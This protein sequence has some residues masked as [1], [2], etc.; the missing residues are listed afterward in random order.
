M[1]IEIFT[2]TLSNVAKILLF[3]ALGYALR[4]SKSFPRESGKTLSILAALIFSPAYTIRSLARDFTVDTLNQKLLLFGYGMVF[5]VAAVALG[6]LT[7][8]L[9]GRDDM[10]KRVFT[11]A[12]AFSNFGYFGYP[13]VESVFGPEILAD[14]IVFSQIPNVAVAT[15]GYW[16]L[17]KQSN[18]NWK[19][20][21]LSPVVWSPFVGAALGLSGWV[22]PE[23]V[24]G[25]LLALGNCM[26]PTVMILMGFVL[27]GVPVGKLFTNLRAYGISLVR[28][29]ALPLI[30][31]ALF[32]LCG[33]RGIWFF[34]PVL[35]FAMPIGANVVV[36]PESC[37]IDTSNNAK[38]VF[39]SYVLAVGILPVAFGIVTAIAGM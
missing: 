19:S 4:N 9:L 16:L 20:F 18:F 35:T 34:L 7:A 26:S 22:L 17:T 10:E 29:V 11:Y 31:G 8:R 30:S 5:V 37:G 2:L 23:L 33:A 25:T 14:Y 32:Y 21:L 1:N 39:L 28:L 36:F 15:F 13:L 24:D 12:F 27:G 3:I 38:M 6:Y